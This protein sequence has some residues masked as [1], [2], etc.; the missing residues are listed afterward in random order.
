LK[1]HPG[2]VCCLPWPFPRSAVKWQ[3]L[4]VLQRLLSLSPLHCLTTRSFPCP[5]RVR[6]ANSCERVRVSCHCRPGLWWW[7]FACLAVGFASRD[8]TLRGARRHSIQTVEHHL[9]ASAR[10]ASASRPLARPHSPLPRQCHCSSLAAAPPLREEAAVVVVIRR[11]LHP[12][13]SLHS[14]HTTPN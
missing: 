9:P 12:L 7:R 3:T 2:R 6:W 13:C 4:T 14:A 10:S 1:R 11:P 5:A 8:P